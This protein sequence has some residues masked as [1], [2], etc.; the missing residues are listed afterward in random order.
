MYKSRKLKDESGYTLIESMFQL[1]ITCLFIQLF[2]M[3]FFW[4]YTIE[5]QYTNY[6]NTEWELFLTEMQVGLAEVTDLSVKDASFTFKKDNSVYSFN[7]KGSV[8]RQQKNGEGHLP[9]LTG[10]RTI[11]FI[12]E[13]EVLTIQAT[14]EDNTIKKR[15]LVVGLSTK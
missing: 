8:L 4:K 12:Y 2:L 13:Q 3:F 7:Q 1:L 6:A 10:I 14:M 5:M 15:S 11:Q 9:L